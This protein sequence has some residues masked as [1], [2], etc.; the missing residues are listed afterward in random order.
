MGLE[1]REPWAVGSD[2]TD[3]DNNHLI[4]MTTIL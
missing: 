4:G 2:L 3:T 1:W